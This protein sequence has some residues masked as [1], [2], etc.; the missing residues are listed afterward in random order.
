[1]NYPST[2]SKFGQGGTSLNSTTETGRTITTRLEIWSPPGAKSWLADSEGNRLEHEA[3]ADQET[4]R[5]PLRE[6]SVEIDHEEGTSNV[7]KKKQTQQPSGQKGA[8][9]EIVVKVAPP[10][11]NANRG[12]TSP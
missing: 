11:R 12:K 6:L 5:R 10:S 4:S 2:K 1:M 7:E 9:G 8:K 3:E